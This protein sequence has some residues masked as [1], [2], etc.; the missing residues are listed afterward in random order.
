MTLSFCWS[1]SRY[2]WFRYLCM[3]NINSRTIWE[4][5]YSYFRLVIRITFSIS[6]TCRKISIISISL[7]NSNL[8]AFFGC[9]CKVTIIDITITISH[10]FSIRWISY[11][12]SIEVCHSFNSD[13]SCN[14]IRLCT[15]CINSRQD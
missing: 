3:R 9:I 6:H 5:N 10:F 7:L 11:L 12:I 13:I 4:V 14:R 15:C 2:C 1:Y 8:E